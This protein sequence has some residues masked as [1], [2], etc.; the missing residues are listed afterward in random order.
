MKNLPGGKETIERELKKL[1][2][3]SYEEIA[4]LIVFL[5]AALLW[6]VRGFVS[7]IELFSL[8][9]DGTIA[10]FI[11]VLLFTI[12]AKETNGN[13]FDWLSAIDVPWGVVLL[14][15]AG[16]AIVLAFKTLELD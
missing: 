4:V 10:M 5:L 15:G 12:P 14:Y 9:Q 8:V 13:Q 3:M 1:G 16:L 7:D 11:T 2:K 6:I